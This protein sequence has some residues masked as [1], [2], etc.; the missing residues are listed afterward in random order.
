MQKIIFLKVLIIIL[1]IS[2]LANSKTIGQAQT[3][4]QQGNENLFV[5]KPL[6]TKPITATSLS[7]ITPNATI[8]EMIDQVNYTDVYSLT[9]ALSG[10]WEVT[11]DGQPYTILTRHT[12][13]GESIQKA[14]QY[15]GELFS[16]FYL[17]VEYHQWGAITHPN[18][19]A[20]L[21]G[22][23]KP[24]EIYIIGA[25]LDNLPL[26]ERAPGADD[27]ASGSVAVLMAADILSQYQWDCTLRFALWTGE[28]Q[29]LK[30]SSAYA[31]RAYE[32][33]ENI[34]GYLNLDMIAWNTAS[35]SPDIDLH[36]DS[37][38]P[39][40]LELA[41]VFSETISA[42]QLNLIP[43]IL[44]NGT[45]HSDHA[46]FWDYGYPAFL[47][48]EDFSDF[49]PLYH[50]VDDDMDN[51]QDWAYYVEFVKAVIGSFAHMSNCLILD[52]LGS[53]TGYVTDSDSEQAVTNA[54][55]KVV[56]ENG[57]TLQINSDSSGYY[58]KE[59]TAGTYTV[60]ASAE[61]YFPTTI[62]NIAIISD[63][64]TTQD[65][66]LQ[67][68]PPD[69]QVSP[70]EI[71]AQTAIGMQSSRIL[72]LENTGHSFLT[73]SVTQSGPSNWLS[74]ITSTNS[75]APAASTEVIISMDA[76]TLEAGT[77]TTTLTIHSNAPLHPVS[78]IPITLEV[79]AFCTPISNVGFSW[80]PQ[81]PTVNETVTFSSTTTG[82]RPVLTWNLADEVMVNG[83]VVT[84]TYT[85]KGIYTITLTATNYCS[86][87]IQ[88]SQPLTVTLQKVFLPYVKKD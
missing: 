84:H 70:H 40:S 11:I 65:F 72:T 66:T 54:S 29:G 57:H 62:S 20:E 24:D 30:G 82:T 64:T 34:A 44:P 8:Q 37:D 27:N 71:I 86:D 42:Y 6:T 56:D 41:Q 46:S 15:V 58:L 21:S 3:V 39:R 5:S 19:I 60:T 79:D 17:P 76:T 88:V 67:P 31:Q 43:E 51:F 74:I 23:S 25:H 59:L 77:Y 68:L 12:S 7:A 78:T 63:T 22:V 18:V 55:L 61:G 73:Y 83:E 10:E 2:L 87:E 33:D 16:N 9:G 48:I 85:S 13:S 4:V 32:N 38:I 81:N 45:T 75:I 80:K 47:A 28:E 69:L 36:A 52:D 49:N 1:L 14:T 26:S 35:S 53:L 50:T